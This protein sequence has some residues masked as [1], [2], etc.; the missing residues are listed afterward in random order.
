[1]HLDG[2]PAAVIA[3]W[4]GHTDARFTLSVY[5]HAN[6]AALTDAAASLSKVAGKRPAE[7]VAYRLDLEWVNVGHPATPANGPVA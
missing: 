7:K 3:A 2:V 6:D 4:L 5:A 1:M